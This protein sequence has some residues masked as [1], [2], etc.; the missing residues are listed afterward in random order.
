MPTTF[1]SNAFLLITTWLV[2]FL[3][4]ISIIYVILQDINLLTI[5]SFN[6]SSSLG[7]KQYAVCNRPICFMS[8]NLG[9]DDH[10]GKKTVT[11]F[12]KS[13][14]DPPNK[15]WAAQAPY[16]GRK[17]KNRKEKL[18]MT[19]AAFSMCCFFN[20]SKKQQITAIHCVLEN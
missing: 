2:I 3:M 5:A 1:L 19:L 13:S 11:W 4:L 10:H 15:E 20:I 12:S 16:D 17:K 9:R 18:S 8:V 7:K 6:R 14:G